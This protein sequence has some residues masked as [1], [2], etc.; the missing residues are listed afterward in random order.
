MPF[1]PPD[2]SNHSFVRQQGKAVIPADFGEYAGAAAEAFLYNDRSISRPLNMAREYRQV[3]D[4]YRNVTGRSFQ[5]HGRRPGGRGGRT[6]VIDVIPHGEESIA[7]FWDRMAEE[8]NRSPELA[9]ALGARSHNDIMQRVY[10]EAQRLEAQREDVGARASG[11]AALGGVAGEISAVVTDPPIAA[12]MLLAAPLGSSIL[13]GMLIEAGIAGGSEALV[14]PIVQSFRGEAGLEAGFGKGVENVLTA[15]TAGAGLY[16]AFRVAGMGAAEL[17]KLVRGDRNTENATRGTLDISEMTDEQRAAALEVEK[18]AAIET[19]Q[20]IGMPTPEDEAAHLRRIEEARL[21]LVQG[22]AVRARADDQTLDLGME[23]ISLNGLAKRLRSLEAVGLDLDEMLPNLGRV[24]DATNNGLEA[25]IARSRVD[26]VVR[27]LRSAVVEERPVLEAVRDAET[28]LADVLERQQANQTAQIRALMTEEQPVPQ[29]LIGQDE[30]IG[31]LDAADRA[32]VAQLGRQIE[33]AGN[34]AVS[35][36]ARAQ[37]GRLLDKGR[38]RVE[39]QR[40]RMAEANAAREAEI[41]RLQ[42]EEDA[43]E[44]ER[45]AAMNAREEAGEALLAARRRR[46]QAAGQFNERIGAALSDAELRRL[47]TEHLVEGKI[48]GD[49]PDGQVR[50]AQE[51]EEDYARLIEE[52]QGEAEPRISEARQQELSDEAVAALPEGARIE[53]EDGRAI[54]PEQAVREIDE[55]RAFIEEFKRCFANANA[56]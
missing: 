21:A 3:L 36:Q 5:Y 30:A 42:D 55:E 29:G 38:K 27:E 50:R 45:V 14:Q 56:S 48:H 24:L 46:E 31:A 15:A 6:D 8:M 41:R 35:R 20:P 40:Q 1:I 17:A 16:G 39:R 52:Q 51:A 23:T 25:V 4:A 13:G 43:L 9:E 22:R 12:S 26:G 53:T 2:S 49:P 10:A 37:R 54:T 28:R 44:A 7:S 18:A 47:N 11:L 33:T 32:Q 19:S 34:E